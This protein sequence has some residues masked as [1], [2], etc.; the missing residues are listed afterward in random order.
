M[1]IG[2]RKTRNRNFRQFELLIWLIILL[3]GIIIFS[4][5][6][7]SRQNT[8]EIH[9]MFF[10]DVD[11]IIVGSPVNL[12]GV[13]I[14]YVTKLKIVGEDE[15]LV[16]FIVKDRDVKLEK[17]TIAKIEFSGLGGS[18]AVELYP[19]NEEYVQMYGLDT[20]DYIITQKPQ[21]LRDAWSLLFDMYKT[22]TNMFYKV[23]NFSHEVKSSNIQQE[24]KDAHEDV[25]KFVDFYDCWLDNTQKQL[26]NIKQMKDKIENKEE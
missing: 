11:G 16:K 23:S 2:V 14:G 4:F 18:K 6:Y 22:F 25:T 9:N 19:P 15:V 24:K 3:A 13:Q 12:M 21:R 20:N 5:L 26:E 7:N 17:G 1:E 8:F 10:P